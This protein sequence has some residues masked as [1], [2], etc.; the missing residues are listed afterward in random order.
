MCR[1]IF[2]FTHLQ[3]S[4]L[5][6]GGHTVVARCCMFEGAGP[7]RA[8]CI[9]RGVPREPSSPPLRLCIGFPPARCDRRGLWSGECCLRLHPILYFGRP[10]GLALR[11]SSPTR[12]ASV[13]WLVPR[14]NMWDPSRVLP[15]AKEAHPLICHVASVFSAFD[16]VFTARLGWQD[17]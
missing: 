10:L 16:A 4:G 17:E 6:C 13:Q 7:P 2:T 1:G 8:G 11:H 5:V 3:V 9:H 12:V 14:R 15:L